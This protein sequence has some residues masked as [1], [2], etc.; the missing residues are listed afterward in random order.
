[1]KVLVD[2]NI[3]ISALLFPKSKPA[4]ALF[5]TV[6]HHQL[7]FCEQNI[8][9]LRDV[10]NRK[11]SHMLPNAEILLAELSYELIP[12]VQQTEKFI[13]DTKDQPILNAAIAADVDIILTGDKD[14]LSLE[15]AHPKC[16]TA[17]QFLSAEGL[18]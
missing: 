9:E 7:V 10:L 15:S 6:E 17:A 3:I 11:A 16:V 1:M 14:F 4:K 12:A 18:T 5:H 13:R 8:R 2:T